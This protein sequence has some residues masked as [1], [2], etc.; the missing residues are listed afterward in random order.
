MSLWTQKMQYQQ[1]CQ[2][3]SD[4]KQKIFAECLKKTKECI[5]FGILGK[6]F[7]EAKIS[8]V[9]VECSSDSSVDVL[10]PEGGK[11]YN[12]KPEKKQKTTSFSSGQLECNLEKPVKDFL[13]SSRINFAQCANMMKKYCFRK[14][15]M[16]Y[17]HNFSSLQV[18]CSFDHT[19]KE[20]RQKAEKCQLK[21]RKWR[22]NFFFEKI[23]SP[24]SFL[25]DTENAVLKNLS[26]TVWQ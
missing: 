2:K 19:V 14:T 20:F 5:F 26:K 22:K 7:L 13:T 1:P 10:L 9:H 18:E 16:N 23:N 24:Q 12:S 4:K 6:F 25:P 21:V 8:S 15:F 3:I 11:V 17:F